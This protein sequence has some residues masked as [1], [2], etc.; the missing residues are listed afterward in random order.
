MN[1]N[2]KRGQA[3]SEYLILMGMVVGVTILAF[4]KYLPSIIGPDG[5]SGHAFRYFCQIIQKI[6]CS[7]GGGAGCSGSCP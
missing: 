1:I 3:A 7:N 2:K 4:T 5:D 6:N